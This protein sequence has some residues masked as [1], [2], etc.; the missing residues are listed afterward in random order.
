LHGHHQVE[1]HIYFPKFRALDPRMAKGFDL[2]ERDHKTIHKALVTS[3]KSSREFVESIGQGS[4]TSRSAGDAY[5]TD[6]DLLLALLHRHL[7]DEGDLIVPAMLHFGERS[8][9]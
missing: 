3:A 8:V 9:S 7:A 6:S 4:D 5:S 1:D 2:L